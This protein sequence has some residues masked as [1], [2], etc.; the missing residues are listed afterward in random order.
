MIQSA[1]M[2]LAVRV[3]V[4]SGII[5]GPLI[6]VLALSGALLVF[7][8]EIDEAT[9]PPGAARQRSIVA[10]F[11]SLHTS[12]HAG[13]PGAVV[14][15]VLGLIL[16]AEGV[17]GLWLYDPAGMR[18]RTRRARAQR[19]HRVLGGIA[20]VFAAVAGLTGAVL[21]FAAVVSVAD[22][23]PASAHDLI[24]RL[25]SGAFLGWPSRIVYGVVG[26]ALPILAITGY[27]LIVRRPA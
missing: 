19:L 23:A 26:A 11:R 25:H 4:W 15:G 24:R 13:R 2:R 5:A 6:V 10:P 27:L 20:L 22:P 21:A 17:T 3:H 14:V 16:V 9:L 1:H 8:P 7:A 12:L 18:A